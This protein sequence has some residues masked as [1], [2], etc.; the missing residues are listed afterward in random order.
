MANN[1]VIANGETLIDL[2]EDTVT[3]SNMVSGI[4]AHDASGARIVGTFDPSIFVQKSGDTMTGDLNLTNHNVLINSASSEK[5]IQIVTQAGGNVSLCYGE[6]LKH[7]I[8]SSGY[9]TSLTDSNTYTS[10]GKWVISRESD[11]K[12]TIPDWASIGNSTTPV[13]INAAGKPTPVSSIDVS[14][15]D[16]LKEADKRNDNF[17]PS[18]YMNNQGMKMRYEFKTRATIGAPGSSTYVSTLTFT[19]WADSSGGRPSQLSIDSDGTIGFRTSANDSTWNAWNKLITTKSDPATAPKYLESAFS[20]S[21]TPINQ[22]GHLYDNSRVHMRLDG[23]FNTPVAFGNADG[24]TLSF[25]WDNS[26]AYDSQLFIPNGTGEPMIRKRAAGSSWSTDP[27]DTTHYSKIITNTTPSTKVEFTPVTGSAA[28]PTKCW[29][30]K[31][32]K[33]VEVS[34]RVSGLT[35]SSSNVLI[36]TLPVG[37]R[38]QTTISVYGNNGSVGCAWTIKDTGEIYVAPT[39]NAEYLHTTFIVA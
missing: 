8:Y 4:V 2:T 38:P 6:S 1:K 20:R 17:S 10:S 32:G 36:Y 22:P 37:Y 27:N 29:Y 13:Y 23:V 24:F 14:N 26:G 39:N 16:Y 33:I 9:E 19:P 30:A 31:Y 5:V 21:D 11:G 3:P 35:V 7:G 28:N 15:A 34:M 25:F 18:T 12:V